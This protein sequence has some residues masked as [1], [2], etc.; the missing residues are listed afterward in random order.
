MNGTC[1]H[2]NLTI[3][4][5]SIIVLFL[6]SEVPADLVSRTKAVC[7]LF[8]GNH[9]R[10][11]TP[12][13]EIIRQVCT[14]LGAINVTINFL[15]YYLFCPAFCR[16]LVKTFQNRSKSRKNLQVNVFVLNGSRLDE[17]KK[18][19]CIND[20]VKAKILEISRRSIESTFPFPSSLFME[21]DNKCEEKENIQ[22]GVDEKSKQIIEAEE[23][24]YVEIIEEYKI[25]DYGIIMNDSYEN[26][27]TIEKDS[28]KYLY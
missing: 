2:T 27:S 28:C 22:N 8:S 16:A 19:C 26:A 20:K 6:V 21:N 11:N 24:E 23:S 3:T 18:H 1:D 4:L 5:I 7:I 15:F 12:M 25:P 13:L 14:L 9:E 17:N 10:A